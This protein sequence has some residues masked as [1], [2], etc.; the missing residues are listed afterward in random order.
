MKIGASGARDEPEINLT[1]LIDV[2]F[3]LIIFFVVTTSFDPRA[4]LKLQ[5]PS[6]SPPSQVG[7]PSQLLLLVDAQGH[8]FI[9]GNEVLGRDTAT[10]RRAIEQAAQGRADQPAVLRADARTPHQSVVTA[11]DALG[12]AGLTRISIATTPERPQ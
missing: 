5:L 3:T 12:Q 10:L 6:A 11:L 7:E 1:S 2:V 8:Y 9:D 4:A